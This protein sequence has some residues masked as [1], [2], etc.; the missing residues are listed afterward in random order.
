[1]PTIKDIANA[2]GVSVTTVSG[3]LNNTSNAAGPE[4]RRRVQDMIRKM[5]Y[6]PSAVARGLSHRRM[7]TIGVVMD[8]SGWTSLMSDQHLGGI[9]DGVISQSSHLR[10][11]TVLYTE[12]WANWETSLPTL[13][14]GLCDGLI[15]M[16]P[17]V[18]DEFFERLRS[19]QIPFVIIADHRPESDLSICDVDN[20]DAGRQI[21]DHLLDLGHRRIAML[22]GN[23]DHQSP[24]LRAQGYRAALEARGVSYEP[25]LDAVEGAYCPEFG[26][27]RTLS[28]L[29]LPTTSRP[30]AL[31]CGD[32]R[33]AMGALEA[34]KERGVSVPEQMSVVGINDSLEGRVA[35]VPL[36]TLRQPSREIGVEAVNLVRAHITENEE[37]GRKV[38]IPGTLLVRSTTG[39]APGP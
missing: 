2:C 39:V 26:Y 12:S 33:I 22:R 17:I 38:A 29:K 21:T 9:T 11:R 20:V 4:T 7:G 23:T 3:V 15:L 28:L 30:T 1:M 10:Q 5:N 13:T 36:T 6:S 27:E 14:D 34:L 18:P 16:V 8:P 37:P 25:L 24:I 31:F 35:Q 19:C 32:D